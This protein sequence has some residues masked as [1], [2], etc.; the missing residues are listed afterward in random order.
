MRSL[1]NFMAII[2]FFF[3]FVVVICASSR[4]GS[5]EWLGLLTVLAFVGML[6]L[7]SVRENRHDARM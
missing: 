3:A 1:F 2:G 7:K 5:V 6:I 4:L